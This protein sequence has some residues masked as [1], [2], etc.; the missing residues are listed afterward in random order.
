MATPLIIAEAGVS[1]GGSVDAALDLVEAAAS[2]GADVVKF[3]TYQTKKLARP[4]DPDYDMLLTHELPLGAFKDIA[5]HAE[6]CGIEFCSTPGDWDCLEY[7]V[8]ECGVKRIKIGSDDFTNR[9]LCWAAIKTKLPVMF[10]TGMA[11]Q[12]EIS[13]QMAHFLADTAVYGSYGQITLM[14]CV[15]LYPCPSWKANLHRIDTLRRFLVPVGYSDHVAG[16]TA[17]M[18]AAALGATVI[19]KHIML[20][21]TRPVDWQVS[22]APLTFKAMVDRIRA[23]DVLLGDGQVDQG[24][25]VIELTNRL[26]KGADGLRGAA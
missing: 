19:E 15:S 8:K 11:T 6:S 23:I 5:R 16:T 4:S 21:G 13:Q 12:A 25:D 1:H 24:A 20:Q 26:R 9:Q 22:I 18:A 17:C 2:T 3:Q 7:L 10:S 14:H